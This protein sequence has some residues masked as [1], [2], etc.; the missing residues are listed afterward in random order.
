MW[1]MAAVVFLCGLGGAWEVVRMP[2]FIFNGEQVF[3]VDDAV[4]W[5]VGSEGT[6][7]RTR[8]GGRS[9]EDRSPEGHGLRTFFGG[10]FWDSLEGIVVGSGGW[11]LRTHDGGETWSEMVLGSQSLKDV[12]FSDSLHGWAVG[13]G[14]VIWHTSDGG[15]TWVPQTSPTSQTLE[16]V[17][18]ADSLRGWAVGGLGVVLR[19]QD[20]GRTWLLGGVGASVRLY[21]LSFVDAWRGYVAG[22]GGRVYRT[23]DG[24]QTWELVATLYSGT[25]VLSGIFFA[26]SLRGWA[27]GSWGRVFRTTDGGAHWDTLSPG[28]GEILRAVAFSS[29]DHGVVLS[30]NGTPFLTEDGGTSWSPGVSWPA[31]YWYSIGGWGTQVV[32]A[33]GYGGAF[34]RSGD[35]G[36]SFLFPGNGPTHTNA[37]LLHLVT[38]P[39]GRGYFFGSQGA[40]LQTQDFG[41]SWTPLALPV[42][43]TFQDVVFPDTLWGFAVA[44]DTLLVSWDGG[45]TWLVRA[46]FDGLRVQHLAFQD[47][48]TGLLASF[49]GL[50]R[51][52][53]G[54]FSWTPLP[55][56]PQ[57][58]VKELTVDAS[59]A[60][61]AATREGHLWRST[62]LGASW[63]LQ[64]ASPWEFYDLAFRG[65]RGIALC[66]SGRAWIT[67]DGGEH[68][69]E[70]KTDLG[71]PLRQAAFLTDEVV[72]AVA[73]RGALLRY[74]FPHQ[75]AEAADRF[76]ELRWHWQAPGRLEISGPPK[77]PLALYNGLGR[78]LW[79]GHLDETGRK[80]ISFLPYPNGVY[81]LHLDHRGKGERTWRVFYLH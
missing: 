49:Q 56:F 10:F 64:L 14:G 65:G 66:D 60:F 41:T 80:V 63:A 25:A 43:G 46:A 3:L 52:T 1:G 62:D 45:R 50:Y 40:V 32:L 76:E 35:G 29:P 19:T 48:L 16:A 72:W 78:R 42:G 12:W 17:W 68:W 8:D 9:W 7:L 79:Q 36:R 81:F 54:G 73:L 69:H 55:A 59:G 38:L 61:W 77:A 71:L 30:L 70:T 47:S 58:L 44:S 39:G 18:F 5:I 27:C 15:Q 37:H 74:E 51:T 33:G 13:A 34:T 11:V 20:G 2:E 28:T 67:E 6:V 53:D 21:D 75:V 24:G 57:E 4:G 26:D 22:Y 23:R 31:V